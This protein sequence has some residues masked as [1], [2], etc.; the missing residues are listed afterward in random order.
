MVIVYYRE[1]IQI[2]I[3]HRKKHVGQRQGNAK[4]R[5]SDVFS[6]WSQ[7]VLFSW[8]QCVTM[9]GKICQ[10]GKLIQ[11]FV[12]RVFWGLYYIRMINFPHSWSQSSGQLIIIW[13][14][15]LH[16]E[17]YWW[18]FWSG[19]PLSFFILLIIWLAQG[20]QPAKDNLAETKGKG[21]SFPYFNGTFSVF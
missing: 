8:H 15:A 4:Y 10:S 16:P 17:S 9:L 14:K 11:A 7:T 3:T 21:F 13:L 1:S 18:S 20:P 6:L 19:Q 12:S 5:A 2:K